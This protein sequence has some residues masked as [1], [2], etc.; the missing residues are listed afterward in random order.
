MKKLDVVL[1]ERSASGDIQVLI[2]THSPQMLSDVL[3][4]QITRLDLDTKGR[5]IIINGTDKAYF[6]ANIH[7]ILADGFFLDYTIGEFARTV[8]QEKLDWL[9]GLLEES[10]VSEED[11]AQLE[12]FETIIPM[13]GDPLIRN[14][15]KLLIEQIGDR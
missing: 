7:T 13:I 3:P 6:G 1:K 8:L 2:S 10:N 12:E 15:F 9:R 4:G 5:C 11:M 14:S